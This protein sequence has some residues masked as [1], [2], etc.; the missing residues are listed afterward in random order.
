M[1][2]TFKPSIENIQCFGV[3]YNFY[4]KNL[5]NFFCVHV[6]IVVNKTN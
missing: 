2:N 5:L 1:Y 6:G 4:L 3:G